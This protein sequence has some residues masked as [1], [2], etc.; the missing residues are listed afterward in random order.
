MLTFT[1]SYYYVERHD[2]TLLYIMKYLFLHYQGSREIVGQKQ[3]VD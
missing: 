3:I 2:T 1:N